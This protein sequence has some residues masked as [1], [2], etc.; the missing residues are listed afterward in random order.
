MRYL[1]IEYLPME[2]YALPWD[3]VMAHPYDEDYQLCD[4]N[5]RSL[6]TRQEFHDSNRGRSQA[7]KLVQ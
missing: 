5:V 3:G 2:L 4:R 6:I 1:A 7:A